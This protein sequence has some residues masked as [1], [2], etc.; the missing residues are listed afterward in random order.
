MA[1]EVNI[2]TQPTIQAS[3][4]TFVATSEDYQNGYSDGYD[5][6]KSDGEEQGAQAEY[7][8]FWNTFQQNGARTEYQYAFAY[9]WYDS[10]FK[11]KYPIAV[12]DGQ[13]MFMYSEI[14]EVP[15]LDLT[16]CIGTNSMFFRSKVE[17]I[18]KLKFSESTVIH[19]GMFSYC[20]S[21]V[22]L[23]VEGTLAQNFNMSYASRLSHDSLM[24]I[25][26]A[27]KDYSGSGTTYTL[28]LGATNLAKL[29]DAEKA[30]AT[31]KGW[32]LA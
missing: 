23:M 13:G 2:L 14:T 30:I 26:N 16:N 19:V 32:T 4:K 25:I 15:E 7:D 9:Y 10:I 24:S 11:P 21:L 6:G 17:K 31:Q 22:D 20:Y 28:T 12:R 29:T 8:H 18:A 3:I 1:I 5:K 27:L